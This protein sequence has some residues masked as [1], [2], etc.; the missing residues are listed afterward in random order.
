MMCEPDFSRVFTWNTV[1]Q[2]KSRAE[3]RKKMRKRNIKIQQMRKVCQKG[4]L[5]ENFRWLTVRMRGMSH[6]AKNLNDG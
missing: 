6:G 3:L 4:E 2:N 1:D 5:N